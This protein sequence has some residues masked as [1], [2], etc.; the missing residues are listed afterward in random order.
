MSRLER[1]R[2]EMT[3]AS[4]YLEA[5][6]MLHKRRLFTPSVASTYH[7]G[8]HLARAASLLGGNFLK[9][10]GQSF[11]A[12]LEKFNKRLTPEVER[13][14]QETWDRR[15]NPLL[16]YEEDDSNYRIYLTRELF[17]EIKDTLN[18]TVKIF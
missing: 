8:F 2:S 6:E 14:T 9:G 12:T 3:A 5:A 10:G 11:M 1:I 4:E 15:M 17:T 7:A 13:S 16:E 18:R